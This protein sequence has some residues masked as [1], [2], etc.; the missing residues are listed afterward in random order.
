VVPVVGLAG[1]DLALDGVA[2]DRDQP[3][4]AW[5]RRLAQ[6]HQGHRV[7]AGIGVPP[8]GL[9]PFE[10]GLD[11]LVEQAARPDRLTGLGSGFPA[12]LVD[13]AEDAVG[14][15]AGSALGDEIQEDTLGFLAAAGAVQG[16]GQLLPDHH[17]GGEARR[18][19]AGKLDHRLPGLY[20]AIGEEQVDDD[21]RFVVLEPAQALLD[22]LDGLLALAPCRRQPL[23]DPGRIAHTVAEHVGL[24]VLDV[25][26]AFD[27]LE[28]RAVGTLVAR[29][30]QPL[31]DQPSCRL[32]TV[33][34]AARRQAIGDGTQRRH[35]ERQLGPAFGEQQHRAPGP[36]R[37]PHAQLVEDVGVGGGEVGH[38]EVAQDQPLEHRLVDDPAGHLL[39]RA[40]RLEPRR[41]DGRPDQ[42]PVGRVEVDGGTGSRGLGTERHQD[43]AER[44]LGHGC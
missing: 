32:R 30:A 8:V 37:V 29:L 24:Q 43:E 36:H 27:Q 19:S 38:G 20:R 3:L 18:H 17:G 41:L 35:V 31:S 33:R 23:L 22:R 4:A 1:R 16:K 10:V 34:R 25:G 11:R 7:D 9:E 6:L 39:V 40:Q 42:L 44:A 21:G 13:A 14:L 15:A 2:H 28:D 5:V 12:V 26:K